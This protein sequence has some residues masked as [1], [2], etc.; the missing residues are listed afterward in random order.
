MKKAK[1]SK[2]GTC[3]TCNSPY[4]RGD[5]VVFKNAVH[6]HCFRGAFA[7]IPPAPT[8]DYTRLKA[9]DALE[10]AIKVAAQT[11]GVTDEMEKSW[12]RFEKLKISGLRPGSSQEERT[13]LRLALIES[14]K[15]AF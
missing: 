4:N 10:E 3:S 1:A 6:E 13:A 11:N 5:R 14:I 9:L 15:L 7:V 8:L 12:A 2:P